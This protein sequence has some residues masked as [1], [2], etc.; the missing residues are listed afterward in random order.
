MQVLVLLGAG[1][2][3]KHKLMKFCQ[4]EYGDTSKKKRVWQGRCNQLFLRQGIKCD[5]QNRKGRSGR[6]TMQTVFSKRRRRHGLQGRPHICPELRRA[7]FQWF[8]D[9]KKSV[10]GRIWPNRV[11]RESRKLKK[12]I[13]VE[14]TKSGQQPP[15]SFFPKLNTQWLDGWKQ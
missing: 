14:L 13:L 12:D 6:S 8:V 9:I 15:P 2:I 3:S 10:K 7:L 4:M 5:P 11:L 1:L